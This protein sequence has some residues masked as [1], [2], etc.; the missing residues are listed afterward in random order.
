MTIPD[1]D[2]AQELLTAQQAVRQA[3][4]VCRRVQSTI[5]PD[6]LAKKDKSPVT[7]ADF[8]SQALICRTLQQA[9][10]DDPVI[11]EEGAAELRTESGADFLQQVV[12]ECQAV[13]VSTAADDVC[14]WIDRG[15][16]QEYRPRFWTLDPI[17]GT[18]GF[19]RNEQY[20]VSLALITEGRIRVGVLG[21]PNM[22]LNSADADGPRGILAWAVE[23]Q[24]AF[25]QPLDDPHA[26][27]QRLS[28]STT[29][30][31]AEARFCESVESGHSSHD[32]S[33]QIAAE[34][35]ISREPFRIDSQ[36]KYLAVAMGDADIYLRL[37]TRKGY[38]EKIWD[39]AGGVLVVREAGGTVTDIHGRSPEFCHG[40]TLSK[41]EGMAV[42]NGRFHSAVTDAIRKHGP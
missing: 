40:S 36:C 14:A 18:K 25:L 20:A 30:D 35:K 7:V 31:P 27:I 10:P 32:W 28:V 23:G 29:A 34:L 33:G 11:G 5:Q 15:G 41:N 22:P 6:S 9:F 8:A 38:Q 2:Y 19:L 42:T 26:P 37:P 21:C 12:A 3:A 4:V 13:G 17:D 39:H 16:L 1:S 24:G